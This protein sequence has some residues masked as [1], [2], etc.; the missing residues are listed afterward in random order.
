MLSLSQVPKP[1][2]TVAPSVEPLSLN[3]AKKQVNFPS[4]DSTHDAEFASI[5]EAA[6][7]QWENDTGEHLVQQT[8][9]LKLPYLCEFCF[10]H[11]PVTSITSIQY[12]DSGN[13]TQTLST[14]VYELDLSRSAVRLKYLEDWPTTSDR[15]DASTVTYVLGSHSA[16]STVPAVAKRAML[17]LVGYYFDANRGENDRPNDLAAY[18]RLVARYMRSSYP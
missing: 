5:I 12:Y 15:W 6:R 8:W 18:E 7:Q 2:I 17:L 13:T 3:E 9:E 11:R 14:D 10:P 1:R 4:D 16:S